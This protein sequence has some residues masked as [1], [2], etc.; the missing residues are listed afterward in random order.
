MCQGHIGESRSGVW[1]K[2]IILLRVY[3]WIN[4]ILLI[5]MLFSLQIPEC[6]VYLAQDGV[7]VTDEDYFRTLPAQILFVVAGKDTI[8]QT[9]TNRSI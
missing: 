1:D 8:V 2:L 7:E 6:R 5:C 3:E 4:S 9:G